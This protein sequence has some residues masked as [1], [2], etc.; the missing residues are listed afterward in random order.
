[1]TP[2]DIRQLIGQLI[3]PILV[4]RNAARL[5]FFKMGE[6]AVQPLADEL[7][8]GVT[9]GVGAAILEVMGEI[10]GWEALAVLQDLYFAENTRPAMRRAAAQALKDNDHEDLLR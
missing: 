10:G 2:D 5:V 3:S 4:E 6:D 8:S 1:M 9:E 7:Y